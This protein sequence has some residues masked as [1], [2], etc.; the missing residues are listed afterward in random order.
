MAV[1]Y[2]EGQWILKCEKHLLADF[3]SNLPHHE[4]IFKLLDEGR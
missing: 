1:G 4:K 2:A 3:S